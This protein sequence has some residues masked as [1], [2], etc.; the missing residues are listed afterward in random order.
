MGDNELAAIDGVEYQPELSAAGVLVQ[1]V[2]LPMPT[3][4]DESSPNRST[5]I[6]SVCPSRYDF[7]AS[8]V[9]ER[10]RKTLL[11]EDTWRATSETEHDNH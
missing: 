2:P 8:P 9:V 7:W 1:A 3:P 4:V 10:F 11:M 5:Y 6:E